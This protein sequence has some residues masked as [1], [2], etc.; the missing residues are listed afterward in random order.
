MASSTLERL[1]NS[2]MAVDDLSAEEKRV[3][4]ALNEDEA[5]VILSVQQRLQAVAG[6]VEGMGNTNNS[7]C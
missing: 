7:L 5:E 1:R 3:F 6:E 2:G 4:E